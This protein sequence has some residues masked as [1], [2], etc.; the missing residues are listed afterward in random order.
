MKKPKCYISGQISGLDRR[1]Y[2]ARFG[3]AAELVAQEGY[4]PVNPCSFL[5]C[6][7]PWLYRLIGY[8]LTL[9]YDLWRLSQCDRIY[10]I[11]AWH[12]SRGAK[13]ESFFAFQMSTVN[14]PHQHIRRLPKAVADRMDA[15]MVK[16]MNQDKTESV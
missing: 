6:R 2:L 13:I 11:P 3:R 12:Q 14:D 15:L 9:L 16:Y 7:W 8:R 4:E 10:M 5:V 1:T